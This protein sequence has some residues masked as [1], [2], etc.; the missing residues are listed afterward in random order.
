[1]A[2]CFTQCMWVIEAGLPKPQALMGNDV[3]AGVYTFA[4]NEILQNCN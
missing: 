2:L 3:K 1:M 4:T